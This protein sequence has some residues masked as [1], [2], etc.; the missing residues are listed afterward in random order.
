MQFS[1]LRKLVGPKAGC[2]SHRPWSGND[3][4]ENDRAIIDTRLDG[5]FSREQ[6]VPRYRQ[7]DES[8]N[9]RAG[10]SETAGVAGS[11]ASDLT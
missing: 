2:S 8:S 11:D 9:C 6:A 3:L 10:L 7:W 4:I 5:G 1:D